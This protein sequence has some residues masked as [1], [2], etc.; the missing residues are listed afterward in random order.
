M[1]N[2][3]LHMKAREMEIDLI[4]R[5]LAPFLDGPPRRPRSIAAPAARALGRRLRRLGEAIELWAFFSERQHAV[6]AE[7]RRL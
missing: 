1:M 3:Y 2:D 5:R 7:G 6:R 4:E